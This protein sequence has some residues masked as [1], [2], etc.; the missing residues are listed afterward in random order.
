MRLPGHKLALLLAGAL[1]ALVL[2]QK[3]E[4]KERQ[5]VGK[6]RFNFSFPA[7]RSQTPLDG[8]VLLLL[9]TNNEK[10][11]R[12]QINDDA[13]TQQVFGIDVEG[14]KPGAQAAIE[15]SVLGY[16]LKSLAQVPAGHLLGAR[17][18]AQIRNLQ[19]QRRPYR[20]TA[21][22]SRRRTALERS[23]RQ[24]VEQAQTDYA[25]SEQ[26]GDL[27]H[28]LDQRFLPIPPPKTPSYIRHV[29]IQSERLSKFWGR[30]FYL[31]AAG[32][33]AARL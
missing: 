10:E 5:P 11:P 28:C 24:S 27:R 6:L 21:D 32:A 15:G 2:A 4:L 20:Q 29:K 26:G 9:S 13:N 18:V 3:G 31:G 1:A 30:P 7:E 12:Q 23:A 17:L 22:G 33:R 19:T 14:W 25:R 8:R 16:P